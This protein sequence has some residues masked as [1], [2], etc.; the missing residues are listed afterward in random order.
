MSEPPNKF[1]SQLW[2]FASIVIEFGSGRSIF[3]T[4]S[5]VGPV[6]AIDLKSGNEV[7][8]RYRYADGAAEFGLI[9]SVSQ[10]FC[11]G[12]TRVRISADGKLYTCLFASQGLDLKSYLQSSGFEQE[13]LF[14]L[15]SKHWVQ[16]AMIGIP[17]SVQR[18]WK[19][20]TRLTCPTSVDNCWYLPYLREL[21]V[22]R[23]IW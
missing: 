23:I 7:A 12:C 8:K 4:L 19:G 1:E 15:L 21:F 3:D 9:T 6:E 16:C 10:P 11:G 2:S 17:K 18:H 14:D 22:F 20:A 5:E 13:A